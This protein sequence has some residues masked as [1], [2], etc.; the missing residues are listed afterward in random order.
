MTTAKSILAFLIYISFPLS[1]VMTAGAQDVPPIPPVVSITQLGTVTQNPVIY[2]RDGAISALIDGKSVWVFGDTPMSVPG[3]EGD[4]WDDNS[5]SWT[6]NLD[7]SQ[8][9]NLNH[10][11]LDFTGAPAEFLPYLDWEAKYNYAHDSHHC[12]EKPCGAEFA[13]WPGQPVV[14]GTDNRVLVPYYELW[15]MQGGSSWKTVGTG[16]AVVSPDGKITRP[17]ENPG[18]QTPTL[19]W[20]PSEVAYDSGSVV[21]KGTLY[22]YGCVA[23]FLVMNCQLGRVALSAALDKREWTFYAGNGTWSA[24]PADA[25]TV[26]QGGAAGNTIYY[27]AYLGMYMA[28]YS[29]V[30]SNDIYYRVAYDPWGPWS[31]QT[32]LFTGENGWN[33]TAD[34]AGEA[35][36][37]FAEG[38]GQ[39][40]YVTYAHTTG[41]LRMDLPL[42]K[43]V[44]G[45]PEK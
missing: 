38:N 27:N 31:K 11:Y 24:N 14:D 39:T 28:I 5:L 2:G 37:E 41:F 4:Y 13:M 30:Y 7:A 26:F 21:V 19:M 36:T 16:I 42:V 35:H 44:F 23:G 34:Y 3:K 29:G 20:G 12:T 22:S 9:I 17:I 45:Q 25:V 10:D 32:L 8:G 18:S 15:R 33:N 6:D 43:V 1:I 40:E